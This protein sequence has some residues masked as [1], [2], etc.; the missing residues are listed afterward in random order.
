MHLCATSMAWVVVGKGW[1]SLRGCTINTSIGPF[2]GLG[3]SSQYWNSGM[4]AG[5]PS[6]LGGECWLWWC[7]FWVES[8]DSG[9]YWLLVESADGTTY[10]IW[11]RVLSGECCQHSSPIRPFAGE[12]GKDS[13]PILVESAVSTLH[14]NETSHPTSTAGLRDTDRC[15]WD[16]QNRMCS[17][18][19]VGSALCRNEIETFRAVCISTVGSSLHSPTADIGNGSIASAQ[20]Y[21]SSLCITDKVTKGLLGSLETSRA[22]TIR[23]VQEGGQE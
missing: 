12:C 22:I 10:L 3:K 23:I 14:T 8:A 15:P 13:P 2:H 1:V 7:Q 4:E 21:K 18:S 9:W 11:W 16:M 17:A 20:R 5:W 19:W 6:G